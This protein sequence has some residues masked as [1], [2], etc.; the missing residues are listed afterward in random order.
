MGAPLHG[1]LASLERYGVE[2]AATTNQWERAALQSVIDQ[3]IPGSTYVS[4]GG[5]TRTVSRVAQ[6]AALAV[7]GFSLGCAPMAAVA[8]VKFAFGDRRATSH[9]Q[10]LNRSA[11]AGAIDQRP[12]ESAREGTHYA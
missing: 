1:F 6:T 4:G 12:D 10:R 11:T 2:F 7:C 5:L 9:G 3:L 8:A